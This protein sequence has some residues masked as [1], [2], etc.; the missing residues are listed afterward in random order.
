MQLAPPDEEAG[1]DGVPLKR[2]DAGHLAGAFE[3]LPVPSWRIE[4]RPSEQPFQASLRHRPPLAAR[5]N[6]WRGEGRNLGR[7]P[8]LRNRCQ[9]RKDERQ[10]LLARRL[11]WY[12]LPDSR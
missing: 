8:G 9:S 4:F 1:G 7:L 10:Q 2:L 12:Q 5:G 11:V 6:S 3:A